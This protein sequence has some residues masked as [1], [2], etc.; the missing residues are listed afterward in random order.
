MKFGNIWKVFF[1]KLFFLY[2]FLFFFWKMA[3]RMSPSGSSDLL[4]CLKIS[5]KYTLNQIKTLYNFNIFYNC[6]VLYLQKNIINTYSNIT[7]KNWI[8]IVH[9][10]I[11][12]HTYSS[13]NI[14]SITVK[15]KLK[16]LTC[17]V[18]RIS[19]F[20]KGICVLPHF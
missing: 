17:N 18:F 12:P 10:H 6:Y 20:N 11:V 19:K 16:L 2:R 9:K 3:N 4:H 15:N 1:P 14:H 13:D 5:I 8:F 7:L